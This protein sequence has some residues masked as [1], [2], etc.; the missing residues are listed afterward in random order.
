MTRQFTA[1]FVCSLLI[2]A[3]RAFPAA[4]AKLDKRIGFYQW[5]GVA[6][7]GD[8]AD[9]LTS[10]HRQATGA[11][12][13]VFRF[14]LGSR[15]DYKHHPGSRGNF[16]D[17]GLTGS[18]VPAGENGLTPA[19][20]LALPRY[21]A[22]LEDPK[23]D[24][25]ILTTY[26]S[27]DYG[28]GPDDLDLLRPWS[29]KEEEIERREIAELC[30]FLYAQFGDLNKTVVIANSEADEKMLEIMNHTGSPEIAIANLVAWTRARHETIE[31]ARAAHPRARLRVLHGFEIS[32]VNLAIAAAGE[33]F[34]KSPRGTWNAVRNV[35]PKVQFD[36]LL[37]SAYES[38]NSPYETRNTD[39]DPADAGV[40]LRRDLGRIRDQGRASLSGAGRKFF[41]EHFVA[42]GELGFARERF[43]Q[44]PTGGLLTRLT[45]AIEAAAGWGCPYIV[46][47]Q[48]FD[49]PKAGGEPWGFGMI[50]GRGR[51]PRLR[52]AANGCDTVQGCVGQLL[53]G[54]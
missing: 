1:V 40:R 9:L 50:D 52:P 38:I 18:G 46:L 8:P 39:V 12:A 32:L 14:Y 19:G 26:A 11:G 30:N 15:F 25:V 33:Q 4:S 6:P 10:A 13:T 28:A 16:V 51:A 23:L 48:V 53:R 54:R 17:D 3:G 36:L 22:V 45:N 34:H 37:Y 27:A 41:G 42:V 35:V 20:I 21:R 43:E 31:R 5:D 49:A 29:A 24:T 47:W 7:S 44:L 2:A